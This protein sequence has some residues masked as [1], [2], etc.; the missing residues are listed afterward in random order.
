[1]L[2]P[3]AGGLA[4]AELAEIFRQLAA[5]QEISAVTFSAWSLGR[6]RDGSTRKVGLRLLQALLGA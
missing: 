1:M 5:E 2:Y 3:A 4:A 6:D